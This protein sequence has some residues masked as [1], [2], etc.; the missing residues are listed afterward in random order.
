VVISFYVVL[1]GKTTWVR[2]TLMAAGALLLYSLLLTAARSGII[3]VAVGTAYLLFKARKRLPILPLLAV[4][5]LVTALVQA[6]PGEWR[7]RMRRMF[8][9]ARQDAPIMWRYESS[10][11]A[12]RLFLREP[13]IGL[14]PGN[15]T[16]DYMSPEFRFDRRE[17]PLSTVGNAYVRVLNETGILGFICFAAIV[18][19][20][21]RDLRFAQ[22]SG[23][24]PPDGLAQAAEI[25]EVYIVTFLV[26]AALNSMFVDKYLW[27]MFGAAY[28]LAH[29]RRRRLNA[30]A[31]SAQ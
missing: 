4:A 31:A 15:F 19:L 20:S 18:V 11:V 14:G 9:A 10:K 30:A 2:V 28:A 23:A 21:L 22:R 3:A 16:E 29:I 26:F 12:F 24:G 13:L 8:V 17:R 1:F 27:V 5:L 25:A 6:S 7:D